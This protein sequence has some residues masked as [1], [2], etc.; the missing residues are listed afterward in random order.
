MKFYSHKGQINGAKI[1]SKQETIRENPSK[2]V[3]ENTKDRKS[4]V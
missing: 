1:E 4:V 2:K 3:K